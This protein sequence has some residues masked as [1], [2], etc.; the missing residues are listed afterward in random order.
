MSLESF[1]TNFMMGLLSP[2]I[3]VNSLVGNILLGQYGILTMTTAFLLGILLPLVTIL[4]FFHH[5]LTDSGLLLRITR[6]LDKPFNLMGLS[7]NSIVPILLGFGCVTVALVS[8]NML[9]T[10]K[11]RLIASILLCI[12]VPCSAQVAVIISM[13]FLLQIKY[14]VIYFLSIISIFILLGSLMNILL[15][16][17]IMALPVEKYPLKRPDFLGIMKKTALQAREFLQEAGPPFFLGS[18]IIS[19]VDYYNGFLILRKWFNPITVKLLHLPEEA[20]NLFILSIVKRDIGAMSFY[21]MIK[22]GNFTQPQI[23]VTLIVLTLFVPCFASLMIL[24][25][26]GKVLQAILIWLGSFIVAF[27]VGALAS[28]LLL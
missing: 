23:L 24:F 22:D 4:Y 19:I 8:V 10:K 7:G 18:I 17:T 14:M 25:N 21:S 2:F 20:T 9:G 13:C 11:E 3:D 6:I 5:S 16:G 15:P 27:S 12:A 28:Y 26:N 1:Y